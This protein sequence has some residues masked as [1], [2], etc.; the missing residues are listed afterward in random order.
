[1]AQ[2]TPLA[3]LSLIVALNSLDWLV[4]MVAVLGLTATAIAGGG[5]CGDLYEEFW[6]VPPPHPIMVTDKTQPSTQTYL[7][8]A[9]E[10]FRQLRRGSG[11]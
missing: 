3:E 2:V 5:F 7:R 4:V 1:M 6:K 11:T 9:F 10:F 8:I